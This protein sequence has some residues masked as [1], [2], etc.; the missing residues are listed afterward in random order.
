[1]RYHGGT[2]IIMHHKQGIYSRK[3]HSSSDEVIGSHQSLPARPSSLCLKP[4]KPGYSS[5]GFDQ[6]KYLWSNQGPSVNELKDAKVDKMKGFKGRKIVRPNS[7][8]IQKKYS[9]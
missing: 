1:M 2:D 9:K 7:I 6:T 4:S 3:S 5:I 8:N